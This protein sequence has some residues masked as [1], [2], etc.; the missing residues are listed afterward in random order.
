MLFMESVKTI[1]VGNKLVFDGYVYIKDKDSAETTY[2]RCEKRGMCNGRMITDRIDGSV[3]EYPS[4]HNHAPDILSIEAAKTIDDIKFRSS[5]TDET[6]S[7]VIYNCT[8]TISLGAS[9]KL[10]SKE[11]LSKIVRR[12]RKAPEEDLFGSV[13]TTRGLFNIK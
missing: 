13:Q 6:T 1:F 2:W 5:L 10:P 11:C 9:V 7:A 3:K 12:K 4:Q 8:Q